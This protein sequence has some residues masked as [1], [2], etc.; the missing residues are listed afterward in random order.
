MKNLADKIV[1]KIEEDKI[2]PQPKWKF[3][4]K[5][6][7][8]WTTFVLAVIVGGLAFLVILF[9]LTSNDWDIHRYLH[10]GF[11][12]H[13]IISLPYF[14]FIILTFFVLVAYYNYR[15]TKHGYQY[16]TYL[17]VL[18]SIAL[19]VVL[20]LG[21]FFAGWGNKIENIFAE[22]IP[23]YKG[24]AKYKIKTWSQPEK[25]LLAGEIIKIDKDILSVKDF[26]ENIWKV[27]I[28]NTLWKRGEIAEIGKQ[29]KIIG[30]KKF[31]DEFIAKETRPWIDRRNNHKGRKN[32][33][34]RRSISEKREGY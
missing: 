27:D 2:K 23:Y 1:D 20:G 13:L 16:K 8:I 26:E 10:R 17:I 11:L 19:S 7:F 12:E 18:G 22:R 14:W 21:M 34:L 31:E 6:Y 5:D 3:L 9:S 15:H 30:T 4:V 25:G 24:I 29:I 33:H 28:Q 32:N